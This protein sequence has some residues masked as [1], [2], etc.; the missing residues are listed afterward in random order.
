MNRAI[1]HVDDP[2]CWPLALANAGN[3]LDLWSAGGAPFELELLANAAAVRRLT[4]RG[5]AELRESMEAL[6]AGGVRFAACR[7]AMGNLGIAEADLLP[8]ATPVPSGVAELAE[9]QG[10]GFAYI[11]P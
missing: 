2:A 7:I 1:F 3:L 10:E 4:E 5:S 11:K 8:F 6:A 9:K